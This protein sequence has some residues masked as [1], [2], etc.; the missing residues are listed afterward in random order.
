MSAMKAPEAVDRLRPLR[1]DA[2]RNRA[3]I[4]EAAER[5]LARSGVSAPVDDVAREAGVGVGTLYRHFPTKEKLLEAIFLGRFERLVEE[6]RSR[7]TADDPGAAFFDFLGQCVE[8]GTSKRDLADALAR[9]GID[10]EAATTPERA[11]MTDAIGVLL[12]RAQEAGAV[13]RDIGMPELFGLVAGTCMIAERQDPN[14]C[15]ASRLLSIVCDGLR[16]V[17]PR[18][19]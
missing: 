7:A 3:L 1:A 19:G 5:V 16:A 13:R 18:S 15:S 6:A 11:A 12:E 2:L 14:V 8:L 9:A 4:L 10:V 17:P